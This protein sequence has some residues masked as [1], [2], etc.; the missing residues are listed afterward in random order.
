MPTDAQ[1]VLERALTLPPLERASIV[2]GLLSSLDHP[3]P[4]IDHVWAQEAE[5]RI[6]AYEAGRLMAVSEEQVFAELDRL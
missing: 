6:A 1:K 3:D 4:A 5:D 2:E